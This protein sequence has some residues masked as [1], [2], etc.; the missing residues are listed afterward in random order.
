MTILCCRRF[1]TPPTSRAR[2]PYLYRL[3][4]GWPSYPP[5][6]GFRFRRLPRLA[7]LRWRYSTPHPHRVLTNLASNVLLKPPRHGP[8]RKHRFKKYLYC[9]VRIGCR[10][11]VLTAPTRSSCAVTQEFQSRFITVLIRSLQW[12]R[13][14]ARSIRSI[15]PQPI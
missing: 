11:D 1:E 4:T 3:G 15:P 5:R 8:S 14:W 2:S 7:G 13:S 10:R 12:S 9:C 6:T